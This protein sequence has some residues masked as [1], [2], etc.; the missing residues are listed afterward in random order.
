MDY[1]DRITACW[2]GK[3]IGGTLGAP[4]EGQN[5]PHNLVFYDPIPDKP[6]A[7]DD[8]D[9]QLVWL[10]C[11]EQ[12]D[13]DIGYDTFAKAWLHWIKYGWDEYGVA[14][15]NLKRGI[16]PPLSGLHN[17][18]FIH[19]MGAAIRS[20][21]WACLF[22]NQPDIAA[23]FAKI[24]SSV[25]HAFEGVF[26][27][28]FLAG[29]QSAAFTAPSIEDAIKTGLKYIPP[30]SQ[31]H[32]IFAHT[33]SLAKSNTSFL[34]ARQSILN[35]FYSHNFTDCLMNL[36]FILYALLKGNSDFEKTLLT[37]VNC[38]M[39]SDCTAATCGAFVGIFKGM[40]GIDL[41]WSK[42]I[43]QH[44]VVADFLNNLG[45][46]TTISE[47]TD[48][49][50]RLSQKMK[51]Q[52][53]NFK[54]DLTLSPIDD[55]YSWL[56]FTDENQCNDFEKQ[57]DKSKCKTI[58]ASCIHITLTDHLKLPLQSPCF[59]TNLTVPVDI[60]AFIMIC[61]DAGITAWLDDEM[62]LNYHGR[63]LAIPASH[64]T[65]GGASIPVKL[66][67]GLKYK[68]KI[69]FWNVTHPTTFTV[70]VLDKNN[71]YINQFN[72]NA[73]DLLPK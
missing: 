2:I 18:W 46:P 14:I 35:N 55:N 59:L 7:N 50:V 24:D 60:D 17:N 8:L 48:R 3:C 67:N 37:A 58:S 28:M 16:N 47:L 71:H 68:L 63:H 11:L 34:D 61:S 13:C 49:V 1:Y 4:Y 73:V 25:D 44:I 51:K 26:A 21:I 41:K 66:K 72:L 53:V 38:G 36:G 9:L 69:R 10:K 15:W 31:I 65:E 6:L 45:L 40:K 22:P 23:Y 33:L 5:G 42:P 64:R 32:K 43:G 54:P 57:L 20:E 29:A 39:D 70:A 27:E 30:E 62:I 56:L 52:M 19:G 12:S